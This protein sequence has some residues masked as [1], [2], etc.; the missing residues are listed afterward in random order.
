MRSYAYTFF[1]GWNNTWLLPKNNA[2]P[3]I[4]P[5]D[6]ATSL[7]PTQDFTAVAAGAGGR[8]TYTGAMAKTFRLTCVITAVRPPAITLDARG[9]FFL[10][11]KLAANPGYDP[12]TGSQQWKR[13]NIID[14]DDVITLVALA[15]LSTGDSVSLMGTSDAPAAGAGLAV[16]IKGYSLAIDEV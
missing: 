8:V 9:Q 4:V 12:I 6:L 13:F 16:E 10:G 11:V 14:C 3:V 5:A 7:N 15:P 2:T 1:E